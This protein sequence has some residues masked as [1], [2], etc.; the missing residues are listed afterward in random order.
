MIF[1]G[2]SRP[3]DRARIP[4]SMFYHLENV[5]HDSKGI[6]VA[7]PGLELL[8]EG[9]V[10]MTALDGAV[11]G[12]FDAGDRGLQPIP[13]TPELAVGNTI[14]G[15][16]VVP[17]VTTTGSFDAVALTKNDWTAVPAPNTNANK[18]AYINDADMTTYVQAPSATIGLQGEQNFEIPAP[19]VDDDDVIV[20][21]LLHVIPRVAFGATVNRQVLPRARMNGVGRRETFDPYT[22]LSYTHGVEFV[23]APK[24]PGG[25]QWMGRDLKNATLS[26]GVKFFTQSG[27]P[28]PAIA[29]MWLTWSVQ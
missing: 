6:I 2:M 22:V 17:A 7:R 8:A 25:G 11:D 28:I 16:A 19:A 1:K 12:I 3:R 15:S 26:F 13:P 23:L 10:D 4:E 5:R 21:L 14:P 29:K 24:R 9:G 20:D 18:V 27:D